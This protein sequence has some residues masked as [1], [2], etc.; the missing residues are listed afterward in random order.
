M[1]TYKMVNKKFGKF[2]AKLSKGKPWNKLFLYIIQLIKIFGECKKPSILKY[3]TI[4]ELM[5]G[6]FEI[7][8]YND[9]KVMTK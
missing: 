1:S 9:K 8:K 4:I 5:T 3:V 7:T 2:S 6:W